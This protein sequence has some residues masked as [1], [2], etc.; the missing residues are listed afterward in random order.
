MVEGER[1]KKCRELE[2]KKIQKEKLGDT[3]EITYKGRW[4]KIQWKRKKAD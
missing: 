4:K 1:E 2:R 3:G